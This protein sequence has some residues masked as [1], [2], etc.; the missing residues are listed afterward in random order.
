MGHQLSALTAAWCCRSTTR[1]AHSTPSRAPP[2]AAAEDDDNGAH[3]AK[4]LRTRVIEWRRAAADAFGSLPFQIISEEH[5]NVIAVEAPTTTAALGDA[6]DAFPAAKM[7]KYGASIVAAVDAF[8]RGRP[9]SPVDLGLARAPA[10][11]SDPFDDLDSF[12]A[13]V[14]LDAP[15][16]KKARRH[17]SESS[18]S[19]D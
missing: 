3:D 2:A 9:F 15:A 14:D 19:S 4:A 1:G 5:I 18:A 13:G 16:H 7:K 6:L 17:V 12:I 8:L 11:P 10:P